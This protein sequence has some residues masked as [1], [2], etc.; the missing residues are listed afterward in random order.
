M[1]KNTLAIFAAFQN[2]ALRT[3]PNQ[4]PPQRPLQILL[5]QAQ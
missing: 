3:Q 2:P 4:R 5:P 1:T